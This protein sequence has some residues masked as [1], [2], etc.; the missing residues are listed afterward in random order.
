MKRLLCCVLLLACSA[1]AASGE[2]GLTGGKISLFDAQGRLDRRL[3]G[4]LSG[5]PATLRIRAGVVDFFDPEKPTATPLAQLFLNEALYTKADSLITGVGELRF[6]SPEGNLTGQG[7]RYDLAADRIT[8]KSGF[9]LELPDSFIEGREAVIQLGRRDNKPFVQSLEATGDTELVLIPKDPEKFKIDRAYTR[10]AW[11]ADADTT[12]H[13][14]L[15]ARAI[16]QGQESPLG[17]DSLT[18][19]FDLKRVE[20]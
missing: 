5:P 20:K 10:R 9:R 12:L 8:M 17:G 3:S 4:D 1:W 18:Y 6:R 7:Y 16:Y 14:A 19:K 2:F 11:Y 15:P 13:F